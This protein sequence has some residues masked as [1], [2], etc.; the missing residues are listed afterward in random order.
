MA[1]SSWEQN[2][3]HIIEMEDKICR[4][5]RCPSLGKCIRKPSL[6]KGDLD[7]IIMLVFEAENNF[8]MD[9]NKII[10]LRNLIKRESKLQ[11]IYHTFMVRCCPKFCVSLNSSSCIIEKNLLD[12]DNNCLLTQRKCNGIPI[13]PG[14]EE[15]ISCLP[16]LLEELDILDPRYVIL[17][18]QR[19]SEF[20]LKAYGIFEDVTLGKIYQKNNKRLFSTVEQELFNS[21]ECRKLF[22]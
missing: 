9:I 21:E 20:V 16:F 2:I 14:D 4:C 11:K 3:K 19:V 18:G 8:T 17:F 5:K 15:I 1:K 7:S 6:G 10:A 12:K 22:V 13:T